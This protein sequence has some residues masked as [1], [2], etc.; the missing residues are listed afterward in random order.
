MRQSASASRSRVFVIDT[1]G[2]QCGFIAVVGA[3]AAGAVVVYS[4]EEKVTLAGLAADVEFLKARYRADVRG[5]SEGRIVIRSED[6]SSTYTTE[7]IT[8]ILQEEGGDLFDARSVSLGHTL[9]GGTPSPRDRTRAVRLAI[10]CLSFLERHSSIVKPTEGH[11]DQKR[12]TAL[13]RVTT[14]RSDEHNIGTVVITGSEVRVAELTEM[15][16]AADWKKRTGKK[17]QLWWWRMKKLVEVMGGRLN[18]AKVRD[19]WLRQ[20]DALAQLT[21]PP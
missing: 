13:P 12:N 16:A 10:K 1:Q 9:Q 15:I 3:L 8:K 4:P 19:Y 14:P 5:K 6:A 21:R 2:G 11:V 18:I 20:V 17:E 7:V